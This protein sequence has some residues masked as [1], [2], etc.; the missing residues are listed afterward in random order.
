L[1]KEEAGVGGIKI[2]KPGV[3][4]FTGGRA[5]QTKKRE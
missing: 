2:F 4:P 5:V 1:G 3:N